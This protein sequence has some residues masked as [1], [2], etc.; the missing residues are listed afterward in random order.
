MAA[1]GASA[2]HPDPL[3]QD[4][5]DYVRY[6]R[7]MSLNTVDAYGRDLRRYGEWLGERGVLPS[8]AVIADVQAYFAGPG[9]DGATASVARRTATLRSF[10]GFLAR[11]GV[12]EDDP[13]AALRGYGSAMES[14]RI[15]EE[16]G[17]LRERMTHARIAQRDKQRRGE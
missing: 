1:S 2:R 6:E 12:R 3:V 4:F 14:A 15:V 10:Y 5:L 11:E 8:A 9:G 13:A 7:G 16:Q 17:G